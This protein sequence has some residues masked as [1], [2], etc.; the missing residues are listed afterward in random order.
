MLS[1]PILTRGL[2]ES[3]LFAQAAGQYLEGITGIMMLDDDTDP[4]EQYLYI[5]DMDTA[6]KR[7]H[8]F[9]ASVHIALF[10]SAPQKCSMIDNIPEGITFIV[11]SI[12]LA[13]LYNSIFKAYTT[14]RS[15]IHELQ[16]YRL[17]EDGL[18][19]MVETGFQQIKHPIIVM[20]SGFKSMAA[21]IPDDYHDAITDELKDNGFLAYDTVRMLFNEH[22]RQPGYSKTCTDLEYV[23]EITG[24]R[25][26][27]RFIRHFGNI[28]ALAVISLSGSEEDPYC[29]VLVKDLFDSISSFLMGNE[30]LKH[31]SNTEANSLLTDL[32]EH[33]LTDQN[34]LEMRLKLLDY[35]FGK[36]YCPLILSF[37]EPKDIPWNYVIGEMD[38][39]FPN[40]LI[41]EYQGNLVI[42]AKKERLFAAVTYNEPKMNNFLES[43]NAYM[44]IGR[45]SEFLTSLR[46]LYIQA[47][48]TIRLGRIF[49]KDPKER[50]FKYDDYCMYH[51]V[52]LCIESS[53]NT[54]QFGNMAYL[55]HP[56][57]IALARYDE[58]HGTNLRQTL[59]VYLTSNCNA[60]QSAKKLYVHRNTINYKINLIEEIIGESLGNF[61]FQEQLM[62][63]FYL[64]EYIEKYLNENPLTDRMRD[65]STFNPVSYQPFRDD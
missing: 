51:Y 45:C 1:I 22:R 3:I 38:Q 35:S 21:Y 49:R 27:S 64:I 46:P 28:A 43:Y 7:I 33:R 15:W 23:S 30:R 4:E 55:G 19:K 5:C 40:S 26:F 29:A 57:V 17:H 61:A 58:E 41:T 32:I 20:N 6:L 60:T 39:I 63:S 12:P 16:S 24:R 65:L 2:D 47:L 52:E 53:I 18:Q 10:C 54:Y 8:D 25:T 13:R 50:V 37:G 62:F 56:S 59:F 34:E 48:A 31:L 44:S 42:L 36:Y 14:Y 9:S 11:F